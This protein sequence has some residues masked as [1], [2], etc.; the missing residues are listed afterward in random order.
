MDGAALR[1]IL[2]D[3][4]KRN[5]I[6]KGLSQEKLAEKAKISAGFL[7]AIETGRKWPYPE[8]LAGLAEALDVAV[9]TLFFQHGAPPDFAD[10]TAEKAALALERLT[11][12][13]LCIDG[14]LRKCAKAH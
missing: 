11:Q 4:V 7:S 13:N 2:A 10:T 14:L 8:T 3:N 5:R 6:N 9:G 1:G 12:V